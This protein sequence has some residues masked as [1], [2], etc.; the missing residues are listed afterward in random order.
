MAHTH[1][2]IPYA[3]L[4]DAV[5]EALQTWLATVPPT[6][7]AEFTQFL[8]NEV[9][10]AEKNHKTSGIGL[11]MLLAA[12]ARGFPSVVRSAVDHASFVQKYLGDSPATY[13]KHEPNGEP[14]LARS[15]ARQSLLCVR[16]RCGVV[17]CRVPVC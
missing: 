3:Y 17:S 13:P 8:L 6:V 7:M 10:S 2:E 16:V 1:T 5:A 14:S 15:L 4:D 11:R 12:I 9:F